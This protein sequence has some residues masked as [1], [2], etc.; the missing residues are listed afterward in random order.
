MANTLTAIIPTLQR[1]ANMVG[2]ELTGFIAASFRNASAAQ[3]ALNQTV[4][5]PIVPTLSAASVTPAAT[6]PAGADIVQ[7]AGSIVMNNLRKV[8]W[9]WTGEERR[10]LMNGDIAPYEDII[11]Q[12]L[13]QAM[14]TLVNE[15]ENSLWL[16]AYKGASRGFGTAGTA[17]F[18]TANDLTDIA[19]IARILDDNGCPQPD[20]HLVVG[21][22]AMVNLRGK[23]SV[24]F[25]VNEAGSSET[26]RRGTIGEVMG[27]DIHNSY[28][29]G[30]HTK[31]TGSGYLVNTSGGEAVGQ[32]TITTDTGTGTILAGDI[33]T[34]AGTTHKYAVNTALSGGAFVIGKPGLLV[35]EAD[36]DAITVGN[37]YTPN[38][39]MHR[40]ALHLV[41]R[42]P[43]T[44][45][46]GAADTIEVTDAFSGL[47]F[48]LARYGQYMQSS[49][50][51][52]VLYGVK[53]VKSEFI[54]TLL[55]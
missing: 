9:N 45:D 46:D 21:A 18:G 28:P 41:M 14:R 13:Q 47:V 27:F 50:E 52:R 29:I 36:D 5:Y 33:V 35:A 51:L 10:A 49:F 17:P 26:L 4:N 15:V 31:G 22:A 42:A 25:K 30:V 37:D 55:G 1:S 24:L 8:S 2:R 53:A 16:A 54:A 23:Q 48:Q 20:R 3:A 32:T 11:G 34:F 19:N 38:I 39:A 12:T 7:E 43:D 44:G 6:P 40:N